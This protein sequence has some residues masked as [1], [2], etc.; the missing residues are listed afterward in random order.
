LAASVFLWS[1]PAVSEERTLRLYNT[2]TKEFATIVFRR[3]REY[4]PSG[5]ARLN[6]FLRD[7][8]RG[9]MTKMDPALFDLLWQLYKE[10]GS[11]A[12]IHINSAYRSAETN[13]ALRQ[14]SSG[15]AE[16]SQHIHGRAIDFFIPDVP[17]VELRARALR[18][19]Q[20]GVGYYP[21]SG[22]PFVHID[23]ANARHWPRMTPTQLASVFPR[24]NTVHVA[25]DG[26][27]LPFYELALDRHEKWRAFANMNTVLWD[28]KRITQRAGSTAASFARQ[29]FRTSAA[30][31]RRDRPLGLPV[32]KRNRD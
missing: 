15:V 19:Q 29:G 28:V 14:R 24:G 7:W 20:G 26:N 30:A 18:L 12:F 25:S 32:S 10:T 21:K 23:T 27:P 17:L 8:R 1:S 2:N 13:A 16:Q 5:L 31:I 4:V 3:D 11:R 6:F 22:L 9:A